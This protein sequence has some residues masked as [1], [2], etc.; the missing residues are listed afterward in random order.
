MLSDRDLILMGW[1]CE[2]S[3]RLG[4]DL[5]EGFDYDVIHMPDALFIAYYTDP[6]HEGMQILEVTDEPVLH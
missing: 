2:E 1:V 3:E 5:I 4:R 6:D